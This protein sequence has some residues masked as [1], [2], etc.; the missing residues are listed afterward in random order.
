MR[1]Q[2]LRER[3]LTLFHCLEA[4]EAEQPQ[5]NDLVMGWFDDRMA[6]KLTASRHHLAQGTQCAHLHRWALVPHPAGGRRAKAQRI[7]QHLATLLPVALWLVRP[8]FTLVTTPFPIFA[9]L[10]SR[11]GRPGLSGGPAL[12]SD[13]LHE[14][15][16]KVAAHTNIVEVNLA[17]GSTTTE[18]ALR[19]LNQIHFR[20]V[21]K[22]NLTDESSAQVRDKDG[23]VVGCRKV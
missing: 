10:P 15:A 12:L 4:L 11:P 23:S 20:I 5:D 7:A 2:R 1:G 22:A 16:K 21:E 17:L 8:M 6:A 14:G 19:F 18:Y 13:R 9:A 3:Q